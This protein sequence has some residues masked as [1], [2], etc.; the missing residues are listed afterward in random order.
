MLRN[1]FPTDQVSKYGSW[2]QGVEFKELSLPP[3]WHLGGGTSAAPQRLLLGG[4][5]CHVEHDWPDA[6][7]FSAHFQSNPPPFFH[8]TT[9]GRL[10][11][12]GIP[13]TIRVR[14]INH[15]LQSVCH[16]PLVHVLRIVRYLSFDHVRFIQ[17]REYWLAT[18]NLSSP[19]RI[20]HH[21][22]FKVNHSPT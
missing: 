5:A 11:T 19:V 13:L 9:V 8:L 7:A 20:S 18:S 21:A 16:R 15:Y 12:V 10:P 22:Y 14:P 3:R 17:S 4:G 1:V 6:Y 2:M